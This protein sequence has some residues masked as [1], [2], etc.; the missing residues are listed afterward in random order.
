MPTFPC[1]QGWVT[2]AWMPVTAS[3]PPFCPPA[4]L[5]PAAAKVKFTTSTLDCDHLSV[6]MLQC[7]GGF[8]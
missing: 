2:V 3:Y 1:L 8:A 7:I 6:V 4:A 5:S